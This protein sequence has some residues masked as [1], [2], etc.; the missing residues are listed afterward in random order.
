L[1]HRSNQM[2]YKHR[3]R[4]VQLPP[5]EAGHAESGLGLSSVLD[6][7]D[8]TVAEPHELRANGTDRRLDNGLAPSQ[9]L[10]CRRFEEGREPMPQ[11]IA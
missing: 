2:I 7:E 1:G 10:V 6:V 3:D 4:G 11:G 5:F 8:G 9:Q